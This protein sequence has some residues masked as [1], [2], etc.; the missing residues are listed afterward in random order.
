MGKLT[1]AQ[2]KKAPQSVQTILQRF[3]HDPKLYM[4]LKKTLIEAASKVRR[5]SLNHDTLCDPFITPKT[6]PHE[7]LKLYGISERELK[8]S[9][10]K[11]GFDINDMYKNIYYQ[12][13]AVS[14]LIGLDKEDEALRKSSLLMIDTMLWNGRKMKVIPFCDP[15]IMRYAM[16]YEVKNNHTIKKAGGGIFEYLDKHSIPQVDAKYSKTIP[17]NLDSKTEGLRKLIETNWSRL[18]QALRSIKDAYY[19]TH[20]LGKKEIISGQYQNQYEA[21]EMV[22][23]RETFS[24]TLDRIVDKIQKNAI[25]KRNVILRP[26][27]KKVY[28]DKWN[29]GESTVKKINDWIMDEDNAEELKYFYEL[30]FTGLKPKT[31]ADIC[32]YSVTALA[33]R[34]TGSRKNKELIKA[35]EVLKHSLQDILGDKYKNLGAQNEYRLIQIMSFSFMANAKIQ[36]CK[37]M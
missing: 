1:A 9:L 22:E 2:K 4:Q 15:D 11:V 17:D 23:A 3:D 37:S 29:I 12:T 34:V 5:E 6:L 28:K 18:V 7:L 26:E 33:D 20:K 14:Y 13:L 16:N 32:Q 21:G 27:V 25:L 24:G 30:T 8:Q 35:K 31:E 19:R 10:V 36:L